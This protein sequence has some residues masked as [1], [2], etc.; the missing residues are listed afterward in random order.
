MRNSG[1][2]F[3]AIG[4]VSDAFLDEAEKFKTE[5]KRKRIRRYSALAAV[6]LLLVGIG[7]VYFG[8]AFFPAQSGGKSRGLNE[9]MYYTGPVL[10]LTANGDTEG[11]TAQRHTVFDFSPYKEAFG[12][13]I[14]VTDSYT[15]K[16]TTGRDIALSLRYPFVGDLSFEEDLTPEITVNGQTANCAYIFGAY[17]GGYTGILGASDEKGSMNLAPAQSHEDYRALLSD[18]AYFEDA[19]RPYP[20]LDRE[21]TVYMLSD[22][23]YSKDETV[24]APTLALEFTADYEKTQFLTYGFNGYERDGKT[25][26]TKYAAGGIKYRP[27]ADAPFREPGNAYLILLG[28]DIGAYELKG[29]KNGNLKE[30]NRLYDLSATVTKKTATLKEALY[31][32]IGNDFTQN[33]PLTIDTYVGLVSKMLTEKGILNPNPIERYEDGRL[34]DIFS[35]VRTLD[36][37]LWLSFDVTVPA[38]GEIQI[39]ADFIKNGSYDFFGDKENRHGYEM[40]NAGSRLRFTRQTAELKNTEFV[41]ILAENFGFDAEKGIY[42]TELDPLREYYYIQV[43]RAKDS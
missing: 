25:G 40:L 2:L 19:L 28:E 5:Q 33:T 36:R 9:Y 41:E 4:N 21:V 16:N 10:P 22:Y 7:T 27:D 8:P 31:E 11:I 29:Y 30:N 15:L 1:K 42:F 26:Q 43:Y 39:T 37:I 18:G 34:E 6:F 24:P 13:E 12:A 32:I 14:R 3:D 35:E 17:T 20:D 23:V 38:G